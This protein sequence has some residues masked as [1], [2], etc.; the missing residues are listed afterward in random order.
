METF[1]GRGQV[2]VAACRG[3]QYSAAFQKMWQIY[4]TSGSN[5]LEIIHRWSGANTEPNPVSHWWAS[6]WERWWREDLKAN[7]RSSFTPVRKPCWMD[8]YLLASYDSLYRGVIYGVRVWLRALHLTRS[9]HWTDFERRL[10]LYFFL[11]ISREMTLYSARSRR[12]VFRSWRWSQRTNSRREKQ[13]EL[14][15]DWSAQ[16]RHTKKH[17]LCSNI[18][19]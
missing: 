9:F 11:S 14:R 15:S 2:S 17:C 5:R 16:C 19:F 1:Q 13:D 3:P 7:V 6:E 18:C 4:V 10:N 8:I 12:G